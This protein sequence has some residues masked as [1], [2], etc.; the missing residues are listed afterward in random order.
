MEPEVPVETKDI[1]DPGGDKPHIEVLVP[2]CPG[3]PVLLCVLYILFSYVSW[4]SCSPM[5]PGYPVLLC[6]LDILFSYVSWISC[7]PMCPGYPVLLCVLDILFSCV[8]WI[9]CSPMCPGEAHLYISVEQLADPVRLINC[10]Q[11]SPSELPTGISLIK[12][13]TRIFKISDAAYT[14]D[15]RSWSLQTALHISGAARNQT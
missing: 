8:S 6:V 7:S 11:T 12:R 5:C 15:L 9:S 14:W 2:V 13:R 1:T 4:I 3:Y 10:S